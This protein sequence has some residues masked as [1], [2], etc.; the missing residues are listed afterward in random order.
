MRIR[1][2]EPSAGE[3]LAVGNQLVDYR[4]VS[5]AVSTFFL[6]LSD[7]HLLASKARCLIGEGTFFIYRMG[8]IC[9]RP[10]SVDP[11]D[12]VL[13]PVARGCMDKACTRLVSD[14][15]TGKERDIKIVP[16]FKAIEGMGTFHTLQRVSANIT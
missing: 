16:A 15:I 13:R 14:M 10:E 6:A 12:I 8:N 5:A 9:L 7:D 2:G 3:Q 11:G 4:L 1:V